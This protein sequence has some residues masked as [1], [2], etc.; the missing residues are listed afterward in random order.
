M[1]IT[2]LNGIWVVLVVGLTTKHD[3]FPLS[4]QATI[5]LNSHHIS[6]EGHIVLIIRVSSM[7]HPVF[8]I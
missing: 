2:Y 4:Y 5:I 7:F 8:P 6:L 3:H 1:R